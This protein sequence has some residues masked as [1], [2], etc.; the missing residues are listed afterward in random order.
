M[1]VMRVIQQEWKYFLSLLLILLIFS[2][3]YYEYKQFVSNKALQTS[4]EKQ[5]TVIVNTS[6]EKGKASDPQVVY[7]QGQSS[8]TKEVVYVPKETDAKTGVTEKTDVQFEKKQG[9]IYVKVNGKE[10]E[11]PAEVKEDT[12][13]ENGKLVVTE[14]TEMRINLTTPKPAVNLGL[15]WSSHG[16]AAEINGPLYKNVSWW[17][18]GDQK[19]IAGGVQ[20]PIM[21]K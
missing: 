12:K 7:I 10:F 6:G 14:Q 5:P 4:N 18:F 3:A 21:N 15:G 8:V 11:V 13:F 9:K 20:F 1:T 19:T 16:P 2:V 17:V